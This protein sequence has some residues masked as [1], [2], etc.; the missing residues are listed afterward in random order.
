MPILSCILDKV[1]TISKSEILNEILGS[2]ALFRIWI[3]RILDLFRISNLGFS[4]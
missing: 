4:S 2:E 1:G 3:I